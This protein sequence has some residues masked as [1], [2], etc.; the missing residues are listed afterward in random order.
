MEI[1]NS[2]S[3]NPISNPVLEIFFKES[4][5]NVQVPL[6]QTHTDI[7][8]IANY[9]GVGNAWAGIGNYTLGQRSMDEAKYS[10]ILA[11]HKRES[12]HTDA[13]IASLDKELQ[14]FDS[15]E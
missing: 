11:K 14:F 6:V 5:K 1:E 12:R 8:A 10:T 15:I 3:E 9:E 4:S 13:E 2:D 7:F